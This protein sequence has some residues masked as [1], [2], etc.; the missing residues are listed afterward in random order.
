MEEL[1]QKGFKI[2]LTAI[3][4]EGFDKNW[5]GRVITQKEVEMLLKLKVKYGIN[6]N[7]EGGEYESLVL[8]CPLFTKELVLDKVEIVEEQKN[9]AY[10]VIHHASLREKLLLLKSK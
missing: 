10:L 8:D 4:A 2:V 9:T 5:L 7:G 1:V 3:A 6:I